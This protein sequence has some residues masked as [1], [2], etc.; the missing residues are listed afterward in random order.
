M[1]HLVSTGQSRRR[2]RDRPVLRAAGSA[3]AKIGKKALRSVL[4]SRG[5]Y[6]KIYIFEMAPLQPFDCNMSSV[7]ASEN[8][9]Q[10]IMQKAFTGRENDIPRR[11]PE[12]HHRVDHPT[13]KFVNSAGS[14]KNY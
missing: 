9:M 7:Y 5:A 11:A 10:K 3:A 2:H 4:E 13:R 8:R 12:R 14:H 1:Q 6:P